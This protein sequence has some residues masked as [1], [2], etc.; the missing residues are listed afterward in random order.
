MTQERK[1]RSRKGREGGGREEEVKK[2][3]SGGGRNKTKE[4][5]KKRLEVGERP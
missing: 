5:E 2:E 1:G 3:G 4:V